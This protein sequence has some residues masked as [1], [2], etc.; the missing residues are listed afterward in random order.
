MDEMRYTVETLRLVTRRSVFGARILDDLAEA[1]VL[2]PPG[3][4]LVK[5]WRIV[6]RDGRGDPVVWSMPTEEEDQ[7]DFELGMA[8]GEGNWPGLAKQSRWTAETP[9]QDVEEKSDG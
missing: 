4:K 7:A 3:M 8:Q 9:W 5:E 2:L 1:G 6:T